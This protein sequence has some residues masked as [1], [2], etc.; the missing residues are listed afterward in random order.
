MSRG[1]LRAALM[2]AGGTG[3]LVF[4]MTAPALAASQSGPSVTA[5][6]AVTSRTE[7]QISANIT[8]PKGGSL[9]LSRGS[10]VN[11]AASS[12]TAKTLSCTIDPQAGG[13]G[14]SGPLANGSYTITAVNAAYTQSSGC[15]G[16]L[17]PKCTQY[18]EA[19][20]T[21]T[22]VLKVPP[23]A[24]GGVD[25]ALHGTRDVEISWAPG[26]ESDLL[27][28]DLLDGSGAVLTSFNAGDSNVCSASK[29]DVVV[30]FAADD[31]GGKKDFSLRSWRS[32]G[33][34]DQVASPAS[35][36]TSVT[37]PAPPS[38]SSGGGDTGG[39]AGGGTATDGGSSG[40]GSTSGGGSG[41]GSGTGS[42]GGTS[43][44]GGGVVSSGDTTGSGGTA[45]HGGY[46]GGF[47]GSPGLGLKFS[48]SGG[49]ITLPHL[50][51][52]NPNPKVAIPEGTYDPT[53][54]YQDQVSAEKVRDKTLSTRLVTSLTAFTDTDR[55]W[56]SL[57]GA[58]VLVLIGTHMRLWT[59]SASYE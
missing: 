43:G 33:A 5:P 44:G 7:A 39:G 23:A 1:R 17:Q 54:G 47:S 29:C 8:S 14:W 55:L 40:G 41:T 57:A 20:T 32:D 13:C 4:G 37:L 36:K 49:G 15:G 42:G 38:P 12:S 24:P 9:T 16:A 59:R 11:T 22:V 27:S 56:K 46:K 21:E 50:S 35:A 19:T 10:S 18:S 53:L 31:P 48:T 26:A 28:Y 3:A 58:L 51:N 6:S 45:G 52:D 25:S 2:V 34:G 30:T